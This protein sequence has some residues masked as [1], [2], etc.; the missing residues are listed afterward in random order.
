MTRIDID[1]QHKVLG[2]SNYFTFRQINDVTEP[3]ILPLYN[4]IFIHTDLRQSEQYLIRACTY[5]NC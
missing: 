5:R 4:S 1:S 2:F 3:Y